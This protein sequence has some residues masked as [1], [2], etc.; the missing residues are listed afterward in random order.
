MRKFIDVILPERVTRSSKDNPLE[1]K[2]FFMSSTEKTVSAI[3]GLTLEAAETIP[4]LLPV[5]I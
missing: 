3:L 5:G 2:S 1:E 4:S